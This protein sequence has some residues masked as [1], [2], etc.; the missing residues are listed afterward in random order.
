MHFYTIDIHRVL[1]ETTTPYII[2]ATGFVVLTYTCK[3]NK[4]TL[5]TAT[6]SIGHQA[7]CT[8]IHAVHGICL[9]LNTANGDFVEQLLVGG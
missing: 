8:N 4:Q 1:V 7:C 5:N 2:L 9:A 6:R 3:S